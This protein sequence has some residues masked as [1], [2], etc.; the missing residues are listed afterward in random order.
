MKCLPQH[1]NVIQLL[2]YVTKTGINY[3]AICDKCKCYI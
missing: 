1:E 3:L 2:G